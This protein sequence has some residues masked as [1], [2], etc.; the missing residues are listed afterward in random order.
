MYQSDGKRNE[1]RNKGLAHDPKHLPHTSVKHAGGRVG[2][3]GCH[4]KWF[5]SMMWLLTAAAR[6]IQK[7]TEKSNLLKPNASLDRRIITPNMQLKQPR[8][9]PG[10][11]SGIFLTSQVRAEVLIVCKRAIP[12]RFTQYTVDAKYPQAKAISA[13]IHSLISNPVLQ[14]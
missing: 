11:K 1:Q 14:N 6:S 8:N 13:H 3:Y 7:C 10:P 5:T 2:M 4:W 12:T 9:F